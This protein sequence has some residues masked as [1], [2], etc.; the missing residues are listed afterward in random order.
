MQILVWGT[1]PRFSVL[2]DELS[3][4][5]NVDERRDTNL[6]IEKYDIIILPM[7]GVS[8]NEFLKLLEK[9]KENVII[10]TGLIGNL[11]KLNRKV[12]SFLGDEE[13]R[14]KND[15][16]TVDGIMDYVS[17]VKHDRVCILGFGHIGGKLYN[18]LKESSKVMVGVILDSDKEILKDDAF[19]TF[20][21]GT[22]IEILN[23]SDLIINTVPC[24][25]I[26]KKIASNLKTP[27]LDIASYPH[28][29]DSEVVN[30]NNLNYN[31]YL[32]IP[33]KYDPDRAGKIL[34]KKFI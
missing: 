31:L 16:I 4:R 24:N 23:D 11:D 26:N 10:Y 1:D 28:G 17:G 22:M 21:E 32:G 13:I 19:Y 29:I 34:L 18:R 30:K 6:D 12:I 5:G 20:D 15:D 9:S 2:I 25:I 7:K 27:I 3:K 33:G 8:D 14:N